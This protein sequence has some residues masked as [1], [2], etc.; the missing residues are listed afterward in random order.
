MKM[1]HR[2]RRFRALAIIVRRNHY[3]SQA[4][5][6]KTLQDNGTSWDGGEDAASAI[7]MKMKMGHSER[8]AYLQNPQPVLSQG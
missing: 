5:H 2:T 6:P 3:L 4:L 7:A 1:V 8:E